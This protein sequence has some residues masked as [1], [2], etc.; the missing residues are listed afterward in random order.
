MFC[1]RSECGVRGGYNVLIVPFADARHRS[2]HFAKHGREFGAADEYEYE[3]LADAFMSA[4][5]YTGLHEGVRIVGNDRIRLDEVT[6]HYGVAFN[7]TTLRTYHIRD[8]F[9]IAH[10]GGAA[11]FVAHKCAEVR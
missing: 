2:I 6:R 9:S 8:A 7:G 3:R 11:A 10:W 4:P 5:W 1:N